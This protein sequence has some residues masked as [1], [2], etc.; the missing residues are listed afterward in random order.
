MDKL[1]RKRT[2]A[3]KAKAKAK[4]EPLP[5][6]PPSLNIDI[7]NS[8]IMPS[9]TE[10]FSVLLPGMTAANE[11]SL[12][13]LLEQQR[14]R[15]QGPSLTREEED[16]LLAEIQAQTRPRAASNVSSEWDGNPPHFDAEW[17]HGDRSHSVLTRSSSN[18]SLFSSSDSTSPRKG[19]SPSSSG[20]YGPPMGSGS[21]M[22]RTF[23]RS[24]GF[25]G[26]QSFRDNNYL[27]S[28]EKDKEKQR[29]NSG[30]DHPA[31]VDPNKSPSYRGKA[32]PTV[33]RQDTPKGAAT[34]HPD[35]A[36]TTSPP[37]SVRTVTPTPS[38]QSAPAM[39]SATMAHAAWKVRHPSEDK[40]LPTVNVDEAPSPVGTTSTLRQ[41]PVDPRR[42]QRQSLLMNMSPQQAKRIS[43]A[44][45]EIE[46]HLRQS[47]V[48]DDVAWEDYHKG[49]DDD[50]QEEMLDAEHDEHEPEQRPS[51]LSSGFPSATSPDST[52]RT[53]SSPTGVSF[54]GQEG[55]TSPQR[56]TPSPHSDIMSHVVPPP[57][58]SPDSHVV[59]SHFPSPQHAARYTSPPPQP[60]PQFASPTSPATPP[61]AS[62]SNTNYGHTHSSSVGSTVY[63]EDDHVKPALIPTRPQ[64]A[65][66][67]P[68]PAFGVPSTYVPGQ[69][70]P[71]G[72]MRQA[73]VSSNSS[74]PTPPPNSQSPGAVDSLT[75]RFN[76][77]AVPG[78]RP[79]MRNL[80]RSVSEQHPNGS[81]NTSRSQTP[82]PASTLSG[83]VRPVDALASRHQPSRSLSETGGASW[84]TGSPSAALH[85]SPSESTINEEEQATVVISA[86]AQTPPPRSREHSPALSKKS[87]PKTESP[88]LSSL[89]RTESMASVSST[90]TGP[91]GTDKSAWDR[92]LNGSHTPQAEPQS[93]AEEDTAELELLKSMSGIGKEEL[94]LIQ[95]RLVEKA[96]S[97]GN[98]L[99]AQGETTP[100]SSPVTKHS[101]HFP[102]TPPSYLTYLPS[103]NSG[104]DE[105]QSPL[106]AIAMLPGHV[107]GMPPQPVDP[108][109]LPQGPPPPRPAHPSDVAVRTA[110]STPSLPPSQIQSP[111]KAGHARG[112]SKAR[113]PP[114][115][116]PT[117][118]GHARGESKARV[119]L[120]DDPEAKRDIE[121][122]IANATSDLFRAPSR[123]AHKRAL[124]KSARKQ[125]SSPT[126]VTY[127]ATV[128]TVPITNVEDNTHQ[129]TGSGDNKPK[130]KLSLRWKRKGKKST[131]GTPPPPSSL[132]SKFAT[133]STAQASTGNTT[134]SATSN[135]RPAVSST[136]ATRKNDE[137]ELNGFRF[138]NTPSSTSVDKEIKNASRE[139]E[140]SVQAPTRS[141]P[142]VAQVV[143]LSKKTHRAT[144]SED[145]VAMAKF[146]DAGRAVGLSEAQLQD[147]LRQNATLNRSGTN[148]SSRSH[149]S[150]APTSAR[151]H[152]QSP[153]PS[154][155]PA[156]TVHLGN[157]VKLQPPAS[158]ARMPTPAVEKS[159]AES[160]RS[161][162][163]SSD[164]AD[165]APP[166][167]IV[168][169]TVIMA[170][171]MDLAPNT[172]RSGFLQSEPTRSP[173]RS[174]SIRRKPVPLTSDDRDLLSRSPKSSYAPSASSYTA[175]H[176]SHGP[177]HQRQTSNTSYSRR[178][179]SG[180]HQRHLSA[181]SDASEQQ[182]QR[183]QHP[184]T[185]SQGSAGSEWALPPRQFDGPYEGMPDSA[186]SVRS[187]AQGS[188][189]DYYGG[190][191][192]SPDRASGFGYRDSGTGSVARS[193]GYGNGGYGY[194]YGYAQSAESSTERP[195]MV[196]EWDTAAEPNMAMERPSMAMERPS[197]SV[198]RSSQAV[199]IMEYSDGRV[200]WN[201]VNAM[202]DDAP[203]PSLDVDPLRP[204]ARGAAMRDSM[205]ESVTE[206]LIEEDLPWRVGPTPTPAFMRRP[207]TRVYYT[208]SADVADLIDQLS[209]DLAGAARGRIDIKPTSPTS[210]EYPSIERQLDMELDGQGEHEP[211]QFS[212]APSPL[213][214][215]PKRSA[216][217]LRPDAE[218]V[219]HAYQ[220]GV[221]SGSWTGSDASGGET[222][223]QDR[224]QAL[225]DRLRTAPGGV[226]RAAG[227]GS[228]H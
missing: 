112:E 143:E 117:K 131:E 10:R 19:M 52:V 137:T 3:K 153:Q 4:P 200:V 169:H 44:L 152:G 86:D 95:E 109:E 87:S 159:A 180:S 141:L 65:R 106:E 191:G 228:P 196:Q 118:A 71:V 186:G 171:D 216:S 140:G 75:K 72:G 69:P 147:M 133:P 165:S 64:P 50:K 61:R 119:W 74:T 212:N 24:Y 158:F 91:N 80:A 179:S 121:K 222:T 184:H 149:G 116:S 36:L 63:S 162:R 101:N 45:L 166:V 89:H 92:V 126:L 135:A 183:F 161:E 206:S 102:S 51:A 20:A 11:N 164:I 60:P 205:A 59:P 151:S 124:S 43:V 49:P 173:T 170:E 88:S 27:R 79:E 211:G 57:S 134:V 193:S 31:W 13:S 174:N 30:D 145:T 32:L 33:P 227:M 115:Q 192:M 66:Y 68:S 181:Q 97:E 125:I 148:T 48:M 82:T 214:V 77:P 22:D 223:V 41:R 107:P 176:A 142:T 73:S 218:Q 28:V 209:S 70:R 201:L 189:Y 199:E 182:Q 1:F 55:P 202:R 26:A 219:H 53:S 210:P 127:S 197:M 198:D 76:Y 85:S 56:T 178:Q 40:E 84:R 38:V 114:T 113:V 207:D 167:V 185:L 177:G 224:L 39:Q 190:G 168:S 132:P 15:G 8:L 34:L 139:P 67:T 62:T 144:G 111:T 213:N 160:I 136:P 187:S 96:K 208:S 217:L 110:T 6:M 204:F 175:S 120:D 122:R 42:G 9:M 156:G 138:P 99:C 157:G 47:T 90:W 54:R 23:A 78:A 5:P 18:P 98:Q 163:A 129:R 93:Y 108:S 172:P 37:S 195:I 104:F 130:R 154:S 35:A 7:R 17:M 21:I 123:S 46:T 100:V 155:P 83:H 105:P 103:P 220:A 2:G 58:T 150:T 29:S 215:P 146:F 221:G 225:M 94:S 226:G 188:F 12:R 194:G 128:P 81:Q 16:M 203:R 25:T 14:A